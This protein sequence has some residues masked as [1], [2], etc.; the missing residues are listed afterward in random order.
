MKKH[1]HQHHHPEGKQC[2][3]LLDQLSEFVDGTLDQKLCDEIE[4]HLKTC[5][6]CTIVV[7]S[8]KKTIHLYQVSAQSEQM[9]AGVRERLYKNL[10]LDQYLQKKED[11]EPQQ[12]LKP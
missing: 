10:N 5:E 7:D 8:L 4:E 2:R 11:V 3:D 1:E 6:N 12:N 9:P